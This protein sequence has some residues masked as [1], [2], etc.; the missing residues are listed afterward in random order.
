MN[1]L[2]SIKL[3]LLGKPTI[4]YTLIF[5]IQLEF[6]FTENDKAAK[7]QSKIN[8]IYFEVDDA[9]LYVTTHSKYQLS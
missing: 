7:V 6:V 4:V 2:I 9:P 8:L 3:R 5:E 1:T